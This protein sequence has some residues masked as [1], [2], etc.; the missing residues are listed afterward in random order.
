MKFAS[1]AD[2][3]NSQHRNADRDDERRRREALEALDSSMEWSRLLS[4]S[5][6]FLMLI[7]FLLPIFKYKIEEINKNY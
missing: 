7:L 5:E 4:A 6:M 1:V 3:D 2:D